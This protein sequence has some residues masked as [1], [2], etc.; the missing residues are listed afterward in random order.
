MSGFAALM[1]LSASQTKEA[2]S[3]VQVVLEQRH[4]NEE[5]RRK[6]QEEAER[7]AR[8]EEAKLRQKRFEDEKKQRELEAKREA[9]Q[10]RILAEQMRREEEARNVLLH[11]PKKAKQHGPK[12]PTSQSGIKEE[13]RRR[14]AGDGDDDDLRSGSPAMVLTREE[15]RQRRVEAEL[16]RTYQVKRGS[17][18]Y[19]KAGRRLP[20]GAI[21]SPSGS[22]M[23]SGSSAQSVKARLAALPNTLTKLN[24]NKRDVRTI[25]EILQDRAKAKNVVLDGEDAKEFNDWF[26]KS[27]KK[28][29]NS[30]PSTQSSASVASDSSSGTNSPGPGGAK[31]GSQPPG[32]SQPS[33]ATSKLASAS[34]AKSS[35]QSRP[36]LTAKTSSSTIPKVLSTA[37]SSQP[38]SPDTRPQTGKSGAVSGGA[39]PRS[40]GLPP[41]KR[42]RSPSLSPPPPKRRAS[43]PENTLSSEIWKLFGKDRRSYVARDVLSDDEDME[44]DAKRHDERRIAQCPVRETRRRDCPRRGEAP[45]GRE[46]QA[47]ARKAGH[48]IPV[49]PPSSMLSYCIPSTLFISCTRT[50]H[51]NPHIHNQTYAVRGPPCFP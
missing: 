1:A 28:E 14:R 17:S 44:A 33:V 20:G 38:R 24:V 51:T 43:E 16:R 49:P 25:D 46:A 5:L 12:W 8:E 15:K 27:K 6:K 41:K 21:D 3:A 37:K 45:R 9:D 29:S 2:Q 30:L 23:D 31:A 42:P 26:G 39:P 4:R 7:K 48:M 10:G 22:T 34:A 40:G 13:V 32:K 18:G 50:L 36:I 35:S 11:G 19:S 47:K